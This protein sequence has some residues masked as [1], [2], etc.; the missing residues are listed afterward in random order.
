MNKCHKNSV[1]SF[2]LLAKLSCGLIL[3]LVDFLDIAGKMAI[4]IYSFIFLAIHPRRIM[5]TFYSPGRHNTYKRL[6]SGWML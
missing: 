3:L 6:H 5:H 2:Y 4:G 1:E